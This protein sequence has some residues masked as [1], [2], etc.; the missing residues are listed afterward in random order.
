MAYKGPE[1]RVH[2]VF[3]TRNSEYHTRA[4]ACVAVRNR[5]SGVWISKHEAVGMRLAGPQGAGPY[6]GFPLRFVDG[7]TKEVRTSPVMDIS[8]PG[9]CIVD[10]YQLVHGV[11]QQGP[12]FELDDSDLVPEVDAATSDRLA[13]SSP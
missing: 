4:G 6:Q 11:F 10:A 9:R 3:F 13:S 2:T 12:S 7:K 1:R 5:R 8:R